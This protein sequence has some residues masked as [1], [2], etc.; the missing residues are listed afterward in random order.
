M[1]LDPKLSG[2]GVCPS[3]LAVGAWGLAST[4]CPTPAHTPAQM[5]RL[6]RNY[7]SVPGLQLPKQDK[8]ELAA[9]TH[10]MSIVLWPCMLRQLRNLRWAG[11]RA[12]KLHCNSPP[13]CDCG[14]QPQLGHPSPM[15][16]GAF[17]RWS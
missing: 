7:G 11:A 14:G 12:V 13:P 1:P 10:G 6:A 2:L 16:S 8:R 15:H 4:C 3:L 5:K 9:P 17:T